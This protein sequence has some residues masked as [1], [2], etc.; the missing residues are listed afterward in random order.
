MELQDNGMCFACGK[1]NPIGL[2]LEFSF[3]GDKYVTCFT[4]RLEHQGFVGITHGG[5]LATALDEV[6]ARMVYVKGYHAV[7]AE[8]QIRLKKPAPTGEELTIS[9]W[10][11]S[12]SRKVIDCAA[13]ARD[14]NGELI[15]E[16]V[17]RMVK[18]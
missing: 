3:E 8:I 15:A 14:S 6:M 5:I 2:K 18:V 1:S 7:T 13:E 11:T 12:E 17:G 9:G 10:I 16:A 4:P